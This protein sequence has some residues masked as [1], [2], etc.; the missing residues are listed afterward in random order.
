MN[1]VHESLS[2]LLVAITFMQFSAWPNGGLS[3][4]VRVPAHVCISHACKF[5]INEVLSLSRVFFSSLLEAIKSGCHRCG[6][7]EHS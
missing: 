1:R 3:C 6:L 7:L 5:G 2:V 4:P